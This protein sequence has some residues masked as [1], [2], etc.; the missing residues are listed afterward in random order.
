M[1]GELAVIVAFVC[2]H[3]TILLTFCCVFVLIDG[4]AENAKQLVMHTVGFAGA[5]PS[6]AAAVFALDWLFH[7]Y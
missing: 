7:P 3:L 1:A 5:Q 6:P 2:G 4:G